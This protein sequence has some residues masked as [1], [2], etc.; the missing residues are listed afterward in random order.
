[1]HIA[2]M[3]ENDHG[4]VVNLPCLVGIFVLLSRKL[5]ERTNI[6]TNIVKIVDIFRG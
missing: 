4:E 6:L 1:M 3:V 2:Y 5:V